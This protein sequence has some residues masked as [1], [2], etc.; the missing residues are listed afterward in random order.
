[1]P[2]SIQYCRKRPP[3]RA[4]FLHSWKYSVFDLAEQ[5]EDAVRLSL[6]DQIERDGLQNLIGPDQ[7]SRPPL[8]EDLLHPLHDSVDLR[9]R[10]FERLELLNLVLKTGDFLVN[11]VIKAGLNVLNRF[12]GQ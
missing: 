4:P 1:M 2:L 9:P 10:S 5:P 12:N 8:T 6:P 3:E 7:P 11:G